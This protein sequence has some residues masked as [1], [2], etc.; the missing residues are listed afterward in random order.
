[1]IV[2]LIYPSCMCDRPHVAEA[3]V[4]CRL[5]PKQIVVSPEHLPTIVYVNGHTHGPSMVGE[6]R[7]WRHNGQR[8]AGY[9]LRSWRLATGELERLNDEAARKATR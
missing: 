9:S 8:V 7:Y 2:K 3:D 6:Y 1:M 5:T 4:E